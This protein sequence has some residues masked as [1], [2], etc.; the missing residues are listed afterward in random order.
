MR[1]I[2]LLLLVIAA[3][4][5][6]MQAARGRNQSYFTYDDG[7]T[8][9]RQADD[10]RETQARLNLPLFP[11]DEVTT[12]RRGRT[13]IRL[14]DGNTIALDRSTA[15]RFRSI[16]DSYDGDADQTIA[17]LEYGEVIIRRI[18]DSQEQLRLDTEGASYVAS[19]DAVFGVET[20]AG[21]KDRISVYEGTVEVRTQSSVRRLRTGD[22]G[23]VD[24]DG[25][26]GLVD[27]PI[28]SASD[29]E[30]WF[31]TR[32][33]QYNNSS[34]YLDR[35]LAYSDDDLSSHGSWVFVGSY[36]GWVWRPRVED[37]WRPYYYGSWVGSSS[38][39]LTWVS[40][41]S[42]GWVPYHY[43]RWAFDSQ[44]G[45]VWL[46]G[47]GYAPAWVY[48][49]YGSS[50]VGWA[51]AGWYDCYRPY[52]N[53]AYRPYARVGLDFGFGFYGRLR[54]H[55][56]DLRP[57]T[58]VDPNVLVSNRVDH[59]AVTIDIIRGRLGRDDGF[60][61]VSNAPARFSRNDLKDPTG[62][63]GV[64][65][66]RGV[67]GGPGKDT[68]GPP[69]DMTPFFRRDPE[70]PA[71]V[72]DRIARPRPADGAAGSGAIA[73]VGSTQRGPS[74]G[75]DPST[76]HVDRGV[77]RRDGGAPSGPV[78]DAGR[79][80]RRGETPADPS[81]AHTN[82]P[83]RVIPRGETPTGSGSRDAAGLDGADRGNWRQRI[84]RPTAPVP[85][86][87]RDTATP[88]TSD[89]RDD[90]RG[91]GG[92]RS[93]AP[94][95]DGSR[96][97]RT[98]VVPAPSGNGRS[99]VDRGSDIPRRVIDR[100]GGARL[101]PGDSSPRERQPAPRERD[102]PHSSPPPPAHAT[103]PPPQTHAAPPPP[104]RSAP[105]AEHDNGHKDH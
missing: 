96:G 30:R 39:A 2:G 57:W 53:W 55:D 63:V 67:P 17:E 47:A 44:Y 65:A 8:I 71:V 49:M 103:A 23:H 68:Q 37:G 101:V 33:D 5:V 76:G 61:T 54:V 32:I 48:W 83:S 88:G 52:Y 20:E 89:R 46:P 50:F 98:V 75:T 86:P 28:K 74:S 21:G 85:E 62:A 66:R 72:R 11:G 80:Y 91:S 14:A 12:N 105:P 59:V 27:L 84:A 25:L 15:V 18:D 70:L 77:I 90:W 95:P 6:P 42:W 3:S 36:G 26:Y 13:E 93:E 82:D 102:A 31:L 78:I 81:T 22:E 34:R 69:A 104:E 16:L 41:E 100:I 56:V 58:F 97:D 4:A 94:A 79:P 87:S 10:G 19:G 51:P 45:W 35:S 40:D 1:K 73:G 92:R 38:G 99:P 7:G 29:F 9:I 24:Q 43:G 60:A 64:I